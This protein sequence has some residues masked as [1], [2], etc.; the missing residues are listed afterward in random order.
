[1]KKTILVLTLL[2]IAVAQGA[3][4][5]RLQVI[6]N[7]DRHGRPALSTYKGCCSAKT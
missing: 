7:N 4:P 1:M 2:A 5:W 3:Q 6:F